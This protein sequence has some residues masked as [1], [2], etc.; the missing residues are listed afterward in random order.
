MT[1]AHISS[2]TKQIKLL[3]IHTT[4]NHPVQ[5]LLA[6]PGDSNQLRQDRVKELAA[7]ETVQRVNLHR[8][9]QRKEEDIRS[10]LARLS[11]AAEKCGRLLANDLISLG[12]ERIL[13]EAKAANDTKQT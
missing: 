5:A 9:V 6:G 10:F 1:P 12:A 13:R 4:A 11:G 8:M 3:E 7:L 2:T